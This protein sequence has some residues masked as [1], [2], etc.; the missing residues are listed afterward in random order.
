MFDMITPRGASELVLESPPPRGHAGDDGAEQIESVLWMCVTASWTSRARRQIRDI[1][2]SRHHKS[3]AWRGIIRTR[4]LTA[5]PIVF[6]ETRQELRE[7][8]SINQYT[9]LL[10]CDMLRQEFGA[11]GS[12]RRELDALELGPRGRGCRRSRAGSASS[13]VRGMSPARSAG[14]S[15]GC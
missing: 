7:A 6:D 14:C 10:Y 5:I 4:G 2:V 8:A 12:G 3:R 1:L 9:P 11:Q 15:R 13:G